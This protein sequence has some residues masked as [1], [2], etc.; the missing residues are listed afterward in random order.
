M[1]LFRSVSINESIEHL[2]IEG[3]IEGTMIDT[4]DLMEILSPCFQQNRLRSFVF[5]N[6]RLTHKSAQL[7]ASALSNC[8][9]LREL[10]LDIN[11]VIIGD[12]YDDALAKIFTALGVQ[13]N[14]RELE[15][16]LHNFPNPGR[17]KKWIALGDLLQNTR[18][19]LQVLK[20]DH[21]HISDDGATILGD[22]LEKNDTLTK[23][24]LSGV[25]SITSTGW[26]PLFKGLA[27]NTSLKEINL[28]HNKSIGDEAAVAFASAV[29]DGSSLESLSISYNQTISPNSWKTLLT[30][31]LTSCSSFKQLTLAKNNINDEVIRVLRDAMVN[32]SV[33]KTLHL[34][35]TLSITPNGM[36]S[37]FG[38]LSDTKSSL[39]TL[40]L[41]GGW[42]NGQCMIN[43]E[44]FVTLAEALA[45]NTKL[46]NLSLY[47]NNSISSVGWL[48]F[49]DKMRNSDSVLENLDFSTINSIDDNVVVT[50]VNTLLSIPSLKVLRLSENRSISAVGWTSITSLLQSPNSNLEDLIIRDNRNVLND[51]VIISFANA[52][53]DN[54][55]LKTLDLTFDDE[56]ITSNVTARGWSALVNVL[57]N[58]SNIDSIYNSN[59]T[60]NDVGYIDDQPTDLANILELN[61]NE[62]KEVVARRKIIWYHFKNGEDNVQEFVDMKLNVIPHVIDWMGRENM[63]GRSILYQLTKTMPTL[64]ERLGTT[65][66]GNETQTRDR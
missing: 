43:D 66:N 50:M 5:W 57:C 21:N 1:A 39:E 35:S 40:N 11:S 19:K 8:K 29:T 60:L 24:S 55:S 52:I 63:N 14:L 22:A 37:F 36:A 30:S 27:I 3:D 16:N 61:Q 53:L 58:T 34:D 20:F 65:T 28:S 13:G 31:I 56:T 41:S 42:R 23:L 38:C 33:L 17:K 4:G 45:T 44:C 62:D 47:Y 6:F 59:H 15:L 49:F 54:T 26:V 64:F 32:G 48:S 9:S 12:E 7:L 25:N 18:S 46:A 51:E 10:K 2:S